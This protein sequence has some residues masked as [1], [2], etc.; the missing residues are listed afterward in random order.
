MPAGACAPT[1]GAKAW[2]CAASSPRSAGCPGEDEERGGVPNFTQLLTEEEQDQ[3]QCRINRH[4][5]SCGAGKG[6]TFDEFIESGDWQTYSFDLYELLIMDDRQYPGIVPDLPTI[7]GRVGELLGEGANRP[8]LER[9][10]AKNAERNYFARRLAAFFQYEW[11]KVSPGLVAHITSMFYSAAM[12]DSPSQRRCLT[13]SELQAKGWLRNPRGFWITASRE[14]LTT[15]VE[16][17]SA[18]MAVQAVGGVH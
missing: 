13:P 1:A 12:S 6:K 2:A 14:G 9:P 11:G 8:P 3:M 17:A 15:P 5:Y 10:N 18:F 16:R 7:L 4:H